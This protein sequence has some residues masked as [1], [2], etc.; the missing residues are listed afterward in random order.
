MMNDSFLAQGTGTPS[1]ES[2]LQGESARKTDPG[3]CFSYSRSHLLYAPIV[4]ETRMATYILTHGAWCWHKD[5]PLLKRS[6]HKVI[7]LP[8]RNPTCWQRIRALFFDHYEHQ[9]HRNS[10]CFTRMRAR[11]GERYFYEGIIV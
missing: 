10:S 2:R 1:T 3:A 4:K 8:W 5:V 6:G 9:G 7:A 11:E